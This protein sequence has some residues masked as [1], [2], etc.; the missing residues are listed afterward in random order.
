MGSASPYNFLKITLVS[1][2]L[3]KID[4]ELME[5]MQQTKLNRQWSMV[6]EFKVA[7]EKSLLHYL[8]CDA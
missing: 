8:I 5:K 2:N 4:A 6:N 7:I 1:E 3:L